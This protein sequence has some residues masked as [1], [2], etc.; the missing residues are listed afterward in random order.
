MDSFLRSVLLDHN[1]SR[2]WDCM[3]ECSPLDYVFLVSILP[4]VRMEGPWSLT[5]PLARLSHCRRVEH[6]MSC[7]L[8]GYFSHT[9]GSAF[10]YERR[11]V[12]EEV[13]VYYFSNSLRYLV[14]WYWTSLLGFLQWLVK[15]WW[16]AL[17]NSWTE[18]TRGGLVLPLLWWGSFYP[19]HSGR[20]EL[21]LCF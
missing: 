21:S 5:D 9:P 12:V 13:A 18:G 1:C 3:L 6:L 19:S 10:N 17:L 8:V 2:L 7:T 4:W 11:M 20:V 14:S 15:L 16:L